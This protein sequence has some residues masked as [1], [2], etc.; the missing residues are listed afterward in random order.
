MSKQ[1][2]FGICVWTKRLGQCGGKI[3]V[4][5]SF[6]GSASR[7]MIP[8]SP[9]P[10]PPPPP[11]AQHAQHCHTRRNCPTHTHTHAQLFNMQR[12]P[13][14]TQKAVTNRNRY[15]HMHTT[16]S[17]ATW[18]HAHLVTYGIAT[19]NYITK[20]DCHPHCYLHLCD[21]L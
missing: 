14:V 2:H 19:Y 21:A 4:W 9:A 7:R 15:S 18:S 1:L 13:I 11:H 3:I 16:L 8:P 5:G 12:C 6:F 10:P 17:H 20:T